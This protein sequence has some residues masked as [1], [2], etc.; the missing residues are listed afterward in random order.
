ML[1]YSREQLLEMTI[2]D[3]HREADKEIIEKNIQSVLHAETQLVKASGEFIDVEIR[4]NII[5]L[6]TSYTQAVIRDITERKLAENKLRESE[7]KYRTTIESSYDGVAIIQDATH[8]YVNS[9]YARIYG[10]CSPEEFVGKADVDLI[11]PDDI[12]YIKIRGQSRLKGEIAESER[13][14]HKGIKKNGEFIYVEVS[15]AKIMHNGRPATLI[16]AR[17]I[18]DR[19]ETEKK[20]EKAMRDAELANKSKSEFLAN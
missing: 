7:E 15:V 10:Y 18:T 1:G 14:E 20:L 5:D 2:P 9:S 4:P 8:I 12:E 13:Y 17:D 11:H 3:L 16:Y 19:K 6:E